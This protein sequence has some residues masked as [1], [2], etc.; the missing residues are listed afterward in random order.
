MTLKIR[1][2]REARGWS[3][4]HLADIAGM[5]RSHLAMIEAGTRR[6][7][8]DRLDAIARALGVPTEL[9]FDGTGS[10]ARV[11]QV[12]RALSEA[13]RDMLVRMAEALATK[14]DPKE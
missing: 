10:E 9:L 14:P 1:T 6:P 7:N 2:F 8:T 12:M 5:S 3:Q 4:E 13:D 11:I